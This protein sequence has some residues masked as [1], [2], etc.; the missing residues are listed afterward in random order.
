MPATRIEIRGNFAVRKPKGGHLPY[1]APN[2]RRS[3]RKI[4]KEIRWKIRC[5]TQDFDHR[6]ADVP[7]RDILMERIRP[8]SYHVPAVL[9]EPS[10]ER[11]RT[12]CDQDIRADLQEARPDLFADIDRSFRRT[13]FPDRRDGRVPERRIRLRNLG[14]RT[15]TPNRIE[16]P[17][18][19]RNALPYRIFL[20]GDKIRHGEIQCRNPQNPKSGRKSER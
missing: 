20:T 13:T 6:R 8:P 11:P 3:A 15:E 7:Y 4:R 16:R 17:R 12:G 14:R 19:F 5:P 1:Q 18:V 10:V 9:S 2:H